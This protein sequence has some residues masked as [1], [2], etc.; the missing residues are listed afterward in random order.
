M[1]RL[2]IVLSIACVLSQWAVLQMVGE[3][4]VDDQKNHTLSLSI[5]IDNQKSCSGDAD[6]YSEVLDFTTRY[7]NDTDSQ[8]TVYL[9][10]DV[11]T[12]IFVAYTPKDLKAGKYE[13]ENK[14]DV[15]PAPGDRY[16]LGQNPKD[17]HP[18]LIQPGQTVDGKSSTAVVVRKVESAR[19]PGTVT[20]GKHFL[21]IR[22]LVKISQNVAAGKVEGIQQRG[23]ADYRWTSVLSDPVEVEIPAKPEL[24]ACTGESAR[25]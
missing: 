23:K 6:V 8:V 11:A 15:F 17:E 10:T 22:M 21:Q 2:I 25:H 12:H 4:R 7:A 19:I 13:A 3:K 24:Q 20:A 16:L 9:G 1:K 5:T 18:K 14:S